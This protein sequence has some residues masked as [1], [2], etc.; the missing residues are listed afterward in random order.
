[1]TAI[2]AGGCAGG[3]RV[4]RIIDRGRITAEYLASN[5]DWRELEVCRVGR[6]ILSGEQH[7]Q[8]PHRVP[9]GA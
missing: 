3:R 4:D 8:G 1:M 6:N 9:A 5:T 2:L 7:V